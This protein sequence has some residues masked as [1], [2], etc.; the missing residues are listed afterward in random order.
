[1]MNQNTNMDMNMD[2]GAAKKQGKGMMFGMIA[3]TILAIGGIGFGIYEMSQV[4]TAKQQ[5]AD[6]KIEV[7]KDDGS[8]TTIET[9]QIEV[10]EADKTVVITDSAVDAASFGFKADNLIGGAEYAIPSIPSGET[11]I[12]HTMAVMSPNDNA[13]YGFYTLKANGQLEAHKSWLGGMNEL[14]DITSKFPAKVVNLAV[15][16]I[17]NG[18]SSWLIVLLED[19]T[20]ATL[21]DGELGG[22]GLD[23]DVNLVE[24]ANDIVMVYGN[25]TDSV[26]T[27]GYA[28]DKNGKIHRITITDTATSP[29]T[30]KLAD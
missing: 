23:G 21:V 16:Q 27:L 15:G 30:F 28:Q 29:W 8:T 10:K 14:V 22:T 2:T 20:V 12:M 7:K 26:V 4:K 9:D 5:I 25:F 17:G 24:G 11:T 6:L 19:G 13:P 3:C 18:G 1:M